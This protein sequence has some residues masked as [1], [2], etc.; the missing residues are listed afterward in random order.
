MQ[1]NVLLAERNTRFLPEYNL[2]DY[3]GFIKQWSTLRQFLWKRYKSA[4]AVE[5]TAYALLS[6]VYLTEYT[7]AYPIVSWLLSQRNS[8]GGFRSTQD[9]VVGLEALTAYKLSSDEVRTNLQ[10]DLKLQGTKNSIESFTLNE[11]VDNVRKEIVLNDRQIEHGNL[12][13]EVT[14]EGVA[15]AYVN[16][17]YYHMPPST[18]DTDECPYFSLSVSETEDQSSKVHSITVCARNK[19][20]KDTAMG[21]LDI[22]IVTGQKVRKQSV[23]KLKDDETISTYEISD[24]GVTLY[25]DMIPKQELCVLIAT[26]ENDN[27]EKAHPAVVSVFDYYEPNR[28]CNRIYGGTQ[29]S[30][31]NVLQHSCDTKG[32]CQC[33]EY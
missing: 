24:S 16:I 20:R 27:V 14:G 3:Q 17:Q 8:F 21:I 11:D 31:Q 33:D 9:T 15:Q 25:L 19:Q 32:N 23:E 7:E 18:Q 12:T 10:C 28:K 5:Q 13:M 6:Q 26:R 22:G 1:Y 4:V 30:N 29:G 2:E